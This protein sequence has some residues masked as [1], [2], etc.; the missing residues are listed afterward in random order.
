M[1]SVFTPTHDT[2]YLL[3]CYRS[4]QQ[5]S[6]QTWEWVVVPNGEVEI[7]MELVEDGR[8]TI[9]PAPADVVGI[10]ALKRFACGQARGDIL[11][12]LDHDD[13]LMPDCL[14][15]V[16][17][18]VDENPAAAMV[19]SDFAYIN[20]DG[21][22]S[23]FQYGGRW[24]YKTESAYGR[25]YH[26]CIAQPATP[27]NVAIIWYA[28]NHVRAFPRWAYDHCGGYDETFT[29]LDDQDLM[30]RLFLLGDFVHV[31]RMLYLQRMH[32]DNTQSDA[33]KNAEI[34]RRTVE[35]HAE[36]IGAMTEAYVDRLI[37]A[38]QAA[39]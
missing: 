13:W 35:I 37:A 3:D 12:E 24:Q 39:A 5:Q 21:S 10:G 25:M 19:F 14:A 11:L 8:V 34:Q 31:D 29:I 2:K 23:E 18:A 36:R 16:Q 9:V 15:E 22:P 7:P 1:I 28:P 32:G 30:C 33:V 6:L 26:R 38:R 27:E 17:K 4:L 20:A